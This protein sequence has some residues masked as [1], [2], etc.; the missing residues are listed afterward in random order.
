MPDATPEL[1]RIMQMIIA[2][3]IAVLLFVCAAIFVI[4]CKNGEDPRH[5][6]MDE[7]LAVIMLIGAISAIL[8]AY[9]TWRN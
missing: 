4:R 3:A 9:Y 8:L 1:Q 6:K 2:I 5:K 7:A